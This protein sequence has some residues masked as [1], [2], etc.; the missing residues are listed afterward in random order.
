[1]QKKLFEPP[2]LLRFTPRDYQ[3]TA[4]DK[5][6]ECWDTDERGV[7]VRLFTGGGKTPTACM[8]AGTWL[9]RGDDYL[10]MIISYE[11]Q[12]VW[13]FAEE[14]LDFLGTQPGIEM[15]NDRARASDKVVV[16]SR[17]S[18]LVAPELLD[19]QREMFA[20]YG[21]T[22]LGPLW[23]L[24]A[25]SWLKMLSS[26][27]A[28]PEQI[29]D[30]IELLKQDPE[31]HGD[32]WSRLH[33]F[34]PKLN[35]LLIFDEAHRHV[36]KLRSIGYLTDW[37]WTNP[38]T[39]QLG[40]TATPK[41][42]DGV[43]IGSQMFPAIAADYPLFHY[44]KPCAV[45][46]G[47]AVPYVQKYISVEGVDF[48][49]LKKIAGDF[50][51]SDLERILGEESVLAKLCQPMLDLVGDRRT[52]IFSPG[53]E[54]AANVARFVNAR[55]EA[56]CPECQSAKWYPTLLIGDGAACECGTM[57]ASEHVTKSG[58]QAKTIH[59]GTRPDDRKE[60]YHGHQNGMFQFLSVC[61]LC[62]EGYNDP[63]ISAVVVFRPVSKEASSLA[64]QMK[65]RGCRPARAIIRDLCTLK[66]SEERRALIKESTKPDCLIIDLVGITG[67]GDCASTALIYADGLPDEIVDRMEAILEEEGGDVEEVAERAEREAA[68]EKE[69]IKQERLEAERRAKE[70]FEKRAKANADVAY[71]VH[72]VGHSSNASS[73]DPREATDSQYRF[74]ESLGVEIVGYVLTKKQAGRL[75]DKLLSGETPQ[76]A[77][78]ITGIDEQYWKCK[79]PSAKQLKFAAWK[80]INVS[81]CQSSSDATLAIAAKINHDEF[82]Q[83]V[84]KMITSAGTD[85][86]LSAV[87]MKMRHCGMAGD[88]EL[89]V[90]GSKRRSELHTAKH[91]DF[92]PDSERNGG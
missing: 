63:D 52:L 66:T 24:R 16:A 14:V 71:S 26:N 65:G 78:G 19:S 41:R 51:D 21:I 92:V 80:R 49:S 4:H 15:G 75:I 47:Y 2:K 39:K 27:R 69:R 25:D 72:D 9:A 64:E 61:G 34:D 30:Q 22:D 29:R 89:I 67:L 20:D 28:T 77:T 73:G 12:L 6:F 48:K 55:S 45:K 36:R 17:A 40:L 59:G 18:L 68:E 38:V 32:K 87:G 42:A 50:A 5:A 13:Q 37:F 62:R 33:R 70:E 86:A 10:V 81:W 43:S 3:Q 31:A 83:K 85:A 23:K 74:I 58:Q 79:G 11:Q 88:P 7:L 46:D 8:I 1:M 82:R 91:D 84:S 60:V 56:V 90:L 57:I 35:W 44:T 54:M 53:V 76:E